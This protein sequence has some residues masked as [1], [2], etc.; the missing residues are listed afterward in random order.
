MNWKNK[1]LWMLLLPF[2]SI[3]LLMRILLAKNKNRKYKK[4]PEDFLEDE[5]YDCVYKICKLVLIL[6]NIKPNYEGAE[7]LLNRPQLIIANHRSNLDAV[8]LFVTIY[9]KTSV[10][11]IFIAKKELKDTSLNFLFNLIDTIYLDRENPRDFVNVVEK[12]KNTIIKDKKCLVIFPEGTRNTTDEL[13]DLKPGA[14]AVAYKTLC[15]IQ[16]IV[17]TNSEKNVN[18]ALISVNISQII[19]PTSFMNIP[20]IN[21]AQN[22]QHKMQDVYNKTLEIKNKK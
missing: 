16:I 2:I 19:Q 13:L 21:L 7:S 8:L 15:P 20:S 17:L 4:H 14:F 12:Q 6:K 22:L 10:R 18:D 11:P 1:Y 5:K 3:Y 9:D